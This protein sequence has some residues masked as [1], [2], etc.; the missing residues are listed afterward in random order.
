[1]YLYDSTYIRGK[2]RKFS[3]Q[4]KG[5]FE[6][7]QKISPLMYRVTQKK[8]EIL[9]NPTKIEEIQGKKCIHRN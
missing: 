9:K 8:P 2:A 6:T 3:Y 4:Y 5:P 1:V 7:E